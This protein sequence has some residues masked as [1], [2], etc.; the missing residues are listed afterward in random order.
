MFT[1]IFSQMTTRKAHLTFQSFLAALFAVKL[2]E[3]IDASTDG[4]KSDAAW[5]WR[6]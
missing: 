3:A 1:F 2:R 6:L 4:D 5:A